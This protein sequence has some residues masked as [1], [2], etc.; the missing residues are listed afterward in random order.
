MPQ[1]KCIVVQEP[2]HTTK[3]IIKHHV[4]SSQTIKMGGENWPAKMFS[5]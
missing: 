1:L 4:C 3:L 2:L 5:I